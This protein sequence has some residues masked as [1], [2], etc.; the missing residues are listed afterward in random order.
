VEMER[1]IR[2]SVALNAFMRGVPYQR[3]EKRR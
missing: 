2:R 1:A 3:Y